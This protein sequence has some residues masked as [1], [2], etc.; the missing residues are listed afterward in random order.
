MVSPLLLLEPGAQFGSYLVESVVGRGG[1]GVVYRAR[2]T[3]LDRPVALKLLAPELTVN[4][5]FRA[6]FVRESRLAAAADHPNIIPIY[7]AGDA[8]GL[9]YLAMRFVRGVDLRADLDRR[10]LLPVPEALDVL[11]Q[12]AAAL[13]AAHQAGLVHRDVKP[14]NILLAD[15]P[16][17]VRRHVY[18]T[19]F[20]LTKRS[21]SVSGLTTTGHFLGTL[22]YVAP[23]QIRGEP[24][25]AR[26]DVYALA[27]VAYAVLTG[28]P[29]FDKD[30][31]AAILWSH[32]SA[33]PPRASAMRPELPAAL[34]SALAAGLAKAREDRPPSCGALVALLGGAEPGPGAPPRG[35]RGIWR[36]RQGSTGL[37]APRSGSH[38]GPAADPAPASSLAPGHASASAHAPAPDAA[39][40]LAVAADAAPPGRAPARRRLGGLRHVLAVAAV[41]AVAV[42]AGLVVLPRGGEDWGQFSDPGLPYT[43]EVPA[44]WTP[45]TMDAGDSTVTV[46]APTDLLGLF[47]DD[48]AAMAAAA[49]AARSDPGSV[50]GLAI[51]HRPRLDGASLRSV[52]GSARALLPG[53]EGT[54][55]PRGRAPVGELEAEVMTGSFALSAEQS[56]RVRVLA[57]ESTPHQ[58]FV[59]FAPPAVFAETSGTFDRVAG[60]LRTT[61]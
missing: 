24:V 36:G 42:A 22:D 37:P 55:T 39:P 6:R 30:D 27:C 15:A 21:S 2:D 40:D 12:T 47:A 10:T 35:R 18:L 61:G 23:E 52:V 13:D 57:V 31:E 7:E 9:L 3:R 32:M 56:L 41:L 59:F 54:L 4:A 46:L 11:R 33:E 17:G 60:S 8:D 14:A 51:Y 49:E 1:M 19:D 25:D 38:P 34:D 50:V 5:T 26:A 53:A 43:L 29:P 58:L 48:P 28:R 16:P 45:R 44:D 20:G